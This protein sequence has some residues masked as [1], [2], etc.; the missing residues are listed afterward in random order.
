MRLM[1]KS[2]VVEIGKEIHSF[3]ILIIRQTISKV[4]QVDAGK[5]H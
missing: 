1:L 4:M 5:G 2:V 3:F